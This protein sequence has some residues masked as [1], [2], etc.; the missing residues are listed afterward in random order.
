MSHV[1]ELRAVAYQSWAGS[2]GPDGF[3]P[4][5]RMDSSP[6]SSNRVR[7]GFHQLPRS[8]LRTQ[9]R[10]VSTGQERPPLGALQASPCARRLRADAHNHE[11][12]LN[13]V[14]PC[15]ATPA[16]QIH[17]GP[18]HGDAPVVE[19]SGAGEDPRFANSSVQRWWRGWKR[20]PCQ[21]SPSDR[22]TATRSLLACRQDT[23]SQHTSVQH[24][25]FTSL[26]RIA[27]V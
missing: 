11:R 3:R 19:P 15:P 22:K 23:H 16:C 17:V 27:R 18:C 2:S 10:S 25:L 24:S 12:S 9:S 8:C 21:L 6:G 13:E 26:E 5:A 4:L 14:K 7:E 1:Y 20:G